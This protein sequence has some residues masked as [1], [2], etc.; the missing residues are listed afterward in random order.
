MR[1]TPDV[2]DLHAISVQ[3]LRV[4]PDNAFSDTQRTKLLPV[5]VIRPLVP[6]GGNASMTELTKAPAG[7]RAQRLNA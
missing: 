6:F 3:D 5:R 4:T 1:I 7:P 2:S